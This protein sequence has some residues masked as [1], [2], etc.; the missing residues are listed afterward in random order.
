M[1]GRPVDGAIGAVGHGARLGVL[2]IGSNTVHLLIVDVRL[3]GRPVPQRSHKLTLRLMRYLD[4]DGAISDE[5]V[6]A[7]VAAIGECAEIARSEHLDD[8]VVMA[9]SALREAANGEEVVARIEREADV[10]LDI[11]S[12]ADE[13]RLTFL[14]V[15]RWF[16]WSAGRILL[17]D[18]GGGS[19]EVA[20]GDDE[21]PAIALS[22]PLGAGRSTVG[23]FHADPPAIADQR[24]LRL[25]AKAVLD[26]AVAQVRPYG[27][28]DHVIGSSKTIRSLARLAGNL[29]PGVGDADRAVLTR[30][31][32]DDWVPRLAKMDARSR[33]ALPG[34]TPER[35]F[36]IVAGGIV[37]SEAMR[38]FGVKQLDV[39]P[40]ALREGRLLQMLDRV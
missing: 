39:S 20:V 26:D 5:G 16:G 4:E 40:W 10:S 1:S 13:A 7:L 3:G 9:T 12:G 22:V 33:A 30:G 19:L 2:D 27:K 25:Y 28:P 18:I 36:Q 21:E 14:A 32:L 24:A 38:A 15:R 37:L 34:I 23:F 8:F 29:M 31:Q 35:T 17:L 11:L 6:D